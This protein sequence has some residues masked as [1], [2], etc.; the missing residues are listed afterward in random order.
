MSRSLISF[1]ILVFSVVTAFAEMGVPIQLKL[2]SPS[3]TYPTEAGLSFKLLIL[4]PVSNC[5]LREENFSS[6]VINNGSIS[7]VLGN[8]VRGV[9]D[10]ALSLNQVYDNSKPKTGLSCVDGNNNIVSVSQV[11]NPVAGDQRT[12]RVTSTISG[13][14]ILV[15]FTMRSTPFAIQAESVGGKPAAD[16][17]VNDAASQMNQTNLNDLLLDVG[18][19][20]NLRNLAV[21]GQAITAN[22]AVNF[23]GTLVGDVSGTQGAT[24]V[25][26][27]KGVPVSA[28]APSNNQIL[29]FNGA[30]YV[31]VNLPPA[32]VTSVAGR[33]GAIVL[34]S[35]DISGLTFGTAANTFAQGNDSRI[36]GALQSSSVFSGDVSGTVSSITVNRVGGKTSAEIANSVNDTQAATSANTVSTI[37]KRDGSGNISASSVSATNNSTQNV[38]VYEA[39]NT[40]S[41]R[42]KAPGSFSNYTL[43]LPVDAGTS[44]QVLQT[45][46]SG[47]L[48]WLNPS[49][50]SVT[51]VSASAPLA[52]SGGTTPNITI[53]Q[54]NATASGYLSS[55]DWTSFNN[56]QAA[57]G[58]VPLNAASNLSDV[59]SAATARTNLGLG[60]AA[61]LNVGTSAG[62]V[63][64]G[65]DARITGALQSSAFNAYVAS[66]SCTSTQSM[67]WNSVSSQF[68]CQ[69]INFP[70]DAVT[71]VAGRTGAV[72][73]SSSDI[74]GLGNSASRNV[75]TSAGTVAAGDDSRITGALQS[76][77]IFSGDV[78]GTVSSIN[79]NKIRGVTVSAAAPTLNQVLQYN[80]SQYV[81]ATLPSAPVTTVA[82]R[83]G[84]VVL[85]S[86][87]ISGLSFGT[88]ANTFAQGNDSRIVNAVQTSSVHSGDVS[89]TL[90]TLSVDRIKGVAVSAT[91]PTLN[92][93]LQYNGTQYVPATLPSA[94]VTTVA[95][96]TGAVVL[97]S[98]DIS[99]LTFGTVA[100]TFA[101]GND[102]RIT[103]AL[104]SSSVFSG[105]VSGTISS[106]N[107]NKIRGVAVSATAPTLN[108]VLQYDGSQYVPVAIPSAPVTTV[109]GRTGAI[110]LTSSDIS[111]LGAAAALNL[112]TSAGTVA[113]GDDSRIT[114]AL[115]SSVFNGYVA[116]AS[117]TSAQSMYWNSVSSQFDCQAINFPADAVTSVAGRTGAVVLTSSDISG[118]GNSASLNVGTT[119]GTVAAGDDSRITG[120]LQASSVFSGDVSGTSTTVA[121]NRIRGVTVSATAPTLNQV[122]QY[123][124]S[125]YVPATLPSAPVTTVAGRTGAVVLSSS[126]IS[127]LTFGTAANTF[128]QGND[129]RI[130][131]ALQSS[132]AFSGDVT[133]TSSALAVNRIRGIAVSATAPTL[134]QVLQYD[135]SQY[136]PVALPS[137]P[138]TTV[139]GR[140]G[141][142]VLSSSDISGL[143]FG[144]AANTFAQGNDSR[145]VNAVQTS[146]VHSGDVS[147]TLT[148]LS[149]DRIKGVAVSSTAPTLNQV[150]QYNGTQYVPATLPAA[151]VISVAGKT[152]AVVLTSSDISGLGNSSTRNVGTAAGTVAA[153]D[154]SRIT[155]ALQLTT[156]NGYVASA[157]CTTSQSMYWNSVS[158]QFLCQAI[159][160]PADAVTSVAGKT[161][162][163]VLSSS[164]VSGLGNVVSRNIG[165]TAGTA[166]AGDDSRIVN[167]F[168]ISSTALSGDISGTSTTVS[169]DKIKGRNISSTAPTTGQALVWDGTQWVP[170]TGFPK[171][172]K[173]TADQ[174]FTATAVANVTQLAIPVVAGVSYKYKFNVLYT[175]AGTGTGLRIGITYPASS[176]SSALA[177][178]PGSTVD[179]TGFMF[180]GFI[181]NSGDSVMAA[182]TPAATPTVIM[183]N[184]EGVFVATITGTI[185]LQAATEIAASAIVIKAGSFVEVT[186]MP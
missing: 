12:I 2:K 173:K 80:G 107:V 167:A 154:D 105:D 63:A 35:S 7:L 180:S 4:S 139:A 143:T 94:P 112:G 109:A 133:G 102:S 66:A 169:V 138:V 181:N 136:V 168:Q 23:T 42:I 126:D 165:T 89:G 151:P 39:T 36:T 20:N 47:N 115:Q 38:Y 156:F 70:A 101:Q 174:T 163:V 50:G 77:S 72:V 114:G 53:A 71:S 27:I 135:G 137:A 41:V 13:D 91:A 97:S 15:N 9:N 45:D 113:A 150:L 166:A 117:C 158:S 76:S 54:A 149:V 93:V 21:S 44:G 40:N 103:G 25:D 175:A 83:T 5:I 155:G 30:Q 179:G 59:A 140:T 92:Q 141:A 108:Q 118:L 99:G 152:G 121:V 145:I 58:Y 67:Y 153:G 29:Q 172:I 161:G 55:A 84:A 119:A 186:E 170:T 124:G 16:I 14:P 79:V 184:I 34:S 57:L 178:I 26:R 110:V 130:V 120:A 164:D 111:G 177:N 159:A 95:G 43:T 171:F 73:L 22:S 87:D 162:A 157:N 142:V 100:N 24:S 125:Q 78:S 131:N 33:T 85:S 132:T 183:A 123:N 62:T 6:Q 182:N 60:G 88:A 18:R 86:S 1:L 69:S 51:A 96:R 148:T 3:G 65:D 52:S 116:S 56:K 134:N 129:S 17:I 74:S 32:P 8:G 144:T 48:S 37:V 160:F 49:T 127:G 104:Q 46:G 146:S 28:T 75:G 81:P 90:T 68:E 176:I 31:P 64:A 10:P 147:G 185:Q 128:A 19:F 98:S 82:G 106:I 61:V 11:Y 122:L